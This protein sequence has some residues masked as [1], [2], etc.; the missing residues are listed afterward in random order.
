[1]IKKGKQNTSEE[2]PVPLSL[3]QTVIPHNVKNTR[4]HEKKPA[5]DMSNCHGTVALDILQNI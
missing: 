2:S 5:P 4:H 1:V 3:R